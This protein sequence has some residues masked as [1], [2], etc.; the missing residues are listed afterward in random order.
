MREEVTKFNQCKS[1]LSY[2]PVTLTIERKDYIL[3]M[4]DFRKSDVKTIVNAFALFILDKIEK[5]GTLTDGEITEITRKFNNFLIVLKLIRDDDNACKQ[6][7]SNYHITQF[8][9]VMNEYKIDLK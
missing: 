7:L 6:N 8:V 3:Q 1:A 4:P 5:N 9:S 2:T